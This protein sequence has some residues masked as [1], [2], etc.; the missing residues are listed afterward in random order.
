MAG[1]HQASRTQSRRLDQQKCHH[2]GGI[3]SSET[4]RAALHANNLSSRIRNPLIAP[5]VRTDGPFENDTN[6]VSLVKH[7]SRTASPEVGFSL[8]LDLFTRALAKR[9]LWLWPFHRS[10]SERQQHGCGRAFSQK[11]PAARYFGIAFHCFPRKKNAGEKTPRR[12]DSPGL[13]RRCACQCSRSKRYCVP[14]LLSRKRPSY[15]QACLV[16]AFASHQP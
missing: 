16:R 6:A 8:I 3:F 13:I 1:R 14:H 15:R 9:I 4:G 10:R 5:T 7:A 12:S 11:T 2:C